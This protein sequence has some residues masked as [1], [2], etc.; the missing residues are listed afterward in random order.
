MGW[1]GDIVP[2]GLGRGL[3]LE[4]LDGRHKTHSNVGQIR[5]PIY[6]EQSL[7]SFVTARLPLSFVRLTRQE[8]F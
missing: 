3:A 5:P 8:A 1:M 7:L 2:E 4:D 6:S